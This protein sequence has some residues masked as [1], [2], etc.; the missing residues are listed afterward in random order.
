MGVV[1]PRPAS[2]GALPH[3]RASPTG[4]ALHP[5]DHWLYPNQPRASWQVTIWSPSCAR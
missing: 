4:H 2:G 3:P 5:G 1:V